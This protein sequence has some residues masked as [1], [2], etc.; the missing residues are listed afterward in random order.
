[1]NTKSALSY[2]GAIVIG[3]VSGLICVCVNNTA[4]KL[5]MRAVERM[6]S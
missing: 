2:G 1:M 4:F 3:G 5:W 6:T